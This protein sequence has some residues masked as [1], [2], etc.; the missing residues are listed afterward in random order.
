MM[1]S[2]SSKP[3]NDLSPKE[4][5]VAMGPQAESLKPIIGNKSYTII[6]LSNQKV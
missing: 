5:P 2:K 4:D 6:C 3:S 1:R